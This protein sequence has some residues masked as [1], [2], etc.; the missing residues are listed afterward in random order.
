MRTFPSSSKEL[1]INGIQSFILHGP[2]SKSSPPFQIQFPTMTTL[3][4][5]IIIYLILFFYYAVSPISPATYI[6]INFLFKL[7]IRLYF[8]IQK[9]SLSVKQRLEGDVPSERDSSKVN[10]LWKKS[11]FPKKTLFENY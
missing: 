9:N 6:H 1:Y 5:G 10:I 3:S 11:T 2:Q 8:K 4:C 7:Q